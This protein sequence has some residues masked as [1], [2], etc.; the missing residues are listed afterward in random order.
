MNDT[1]TQ[2]HRFSAITCAL[3]AIGVLFL[4]S[5]TLATADP[6]SSETPP[7]QTETIP[8]APVQIDADQNMSIED[9]ASPDVDNR[10]GQ[11]LQR[12]PVSQEQ[13]QQN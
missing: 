4:A 13:S 9:Q 5:A 10:S 11:T 2:W 7:Q 8:T 3:S 12:R 6:E 1:S